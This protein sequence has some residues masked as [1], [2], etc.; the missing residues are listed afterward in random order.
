MVA[1]HMLPSNQNNRMENIEAHGEITE[2]LIFQWKQF[3]LDFHKSYNT[4]EEETY[5]IKVF[6]ENLNYIE[7]NQGDTYSLAIN[8]FADMTREEF[9]AA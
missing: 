2:E 7:D 9:K 6:I 8:E 4:I 1:L 3:K 5:R